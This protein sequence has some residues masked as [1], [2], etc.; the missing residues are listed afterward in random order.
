MNIGQAANVS[1]VSAKM[2]RYYEATG[3]LPPA[4]RLSRLQLRA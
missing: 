4:E 3:L 1:G 2:I